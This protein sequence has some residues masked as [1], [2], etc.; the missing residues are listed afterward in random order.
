MDFS[1]LY[2]VLVSQWGYIGIFLMQVISSSTV[3][4]PLPGIAIIFV[5]GTILNPLLVGIF[6][7]LGAA[8]GELTGYA[9]GYG[10]HKIVTRKNKKWAKK[11]KKL[12][13]KYNPFVVIVVFAATPLPFDLVGILCGLSKYDIKKF[14]LAA[15]IGNVIRGMVIALAGFYGMSW[16]LGIFGG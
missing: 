5:Y 8:I 15:L 9:V 6:A 7:G 12:F 11:T 4:L 16:I 14:F 2:H 1:A 3:L 13:K 10:G